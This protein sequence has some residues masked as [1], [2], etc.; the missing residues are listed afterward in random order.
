LFAVFVAVAPWIGGA[1]TAVVSAVPDAD[2]FVWSM[3][4][5][6]NYGAGG[7]LSVSGSAAVNGSGVQNGLFDTLMRFPMSN[8][9]ATLDGALGAGNWTVIRARLIVTESATP[10]NAIFN[11]GVGA[12]EVLRLA[13]EAWVEGTGRPMAPTTDGVT[14]SDLAGLVNS[15]LDVPLGIFT[16]AGADVEEAFGLAL[17][18]PF[19]ADIQEGGE[20][21]LHL[22][23]ASPEVGFTFNSRNFGN[24]NAQ[25]VLEVTGAVTPEP[26]ID[27]VGVVGAYVSVSFGTVSNFSYVLQGSDSAGGEGA[28]KWTDLLEVPAQPESGA[29][30]YLD[31]VTNGQR[32][33]RLSVSP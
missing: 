1:Q 20:A 18:E 9:V 31:G 17:A 14:W 2:A 11:R 19:V 25:P 5:S 23:A 4:P 28:G 29:V 15:N 12:F 30:V 26:R 22:T 10:D 8:V 32:F 24:T 7:A 6:N 33:Y 13:S 16:N 27:Q 21:G 3:A